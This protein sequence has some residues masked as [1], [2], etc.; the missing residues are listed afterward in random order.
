MR[1]EVHEPHAPLAPAA[2]LGDQLRHRHHEP[3]VAAL[4]AV[5]HDD[6]RELLPDRH[7]GEDGVRGQPP[8]ARAVGEAAVGAE[9]HPPAARHAER[10]AVAAAGGDVGVDRTQ[11]ALQALGVEAELGGVGVLHGHGR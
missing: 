10:D 8:P 6:V 11:D 7:R 3:Q 1:Q 5:Q 9:R 2:E 4:D